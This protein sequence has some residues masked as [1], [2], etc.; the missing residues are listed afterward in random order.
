MRLAFAAGSQGTYQHPQLGEVKYRVQNLSWDPDTQ[1]GQTL[2]LMLERAAQD[3]ADPW[4]KQRAQSIAGLGSDK[5]RALSL[6]NHA[7]KKNGRIR[8]QR[9]EVTG[10]GVGGYGEDEVIEAS[11]RPLD[12]ARYV[13]D[14]IGMGDCDDFSCYLAALLKANGIACSFVTVGADDRVP[15]QFSH[16]Y[17]VAYPVDENGQAERLP[18]DASHGE[19][20]GWEVPN[21][22]GKYKEWPVWDRVTFLI[23]SVAGTVAVALGLFWAG[24]QVWRMAQ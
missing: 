6:Y 1:V 3:S 13:D 21:Q 14:G 2:G 22:F 4:F 12:M 10:G 19:Y 17:V 5:A 16:V 15:N 20:P 24:K 18:L 23:G 7:W 8:F 9:D 11:I